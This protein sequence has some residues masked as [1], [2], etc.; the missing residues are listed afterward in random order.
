VRDK[1]RLEGLDLARFLAALIVAMGHLLFVQSLITDWAL[2]QEIFK[3]FQF[4]SLSVNFFFC[5]SGFVLSGQIKNIR[6]APFT[7]MFAR[8]IR[9]M[10]LY[11]FC[12]IIPLVIFI[13]LAQ[14][15]GGPIFPNGWESAALG[16]IA[17]QSF[18]SYYL[19]LPNPPLW[20]LSV[21]VWLSMIL[22]A[23]S[24]TFFSRLITM[25]MFL[26]FLTHAILFPDHG[27]AVTKAI[28]LFLFG[29]ILN[30]KKLLKFFANFWPRFL[31]L[32]IIFFC[33]VPIYRIILLQEDWGPLTN[34]VTIIFTSSV[35]VFFST[36]NLR[37]DFKNICFFLGSRTYSLYASHFPVLIFCTKVF[38]SLGN[39]HPFVYILILTSLILGV[40]ELTYRFVEKPS[41]EYSRKVRNRNLKL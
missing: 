7:W 32:A 9:L 10:P 35:I 20:S 37:S 15:N 41:L 17:S 8:L 16:L 24:L 22:V 27:S 34:L 36:V 12:W 40:T 14:R 19:D 25:I 29:I 31:I 28:H 33:I 3:V 13:G 23:I 26:V 6:E 11:Y 38:S 18:T 30:D 5:L 21:E 1:N 39:L 4:G 2:N